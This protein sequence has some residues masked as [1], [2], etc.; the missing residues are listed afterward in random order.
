MPRSSIFHKVSTSDSLFLSTFI[1][2]KCDSFIVLSSFADDIKMHFDNK[3]V[4]DCNMLQQD[5]DSMQKWC[6]D[7]CMKLNI[8][9]STIIYL[10]TK[11]KVLN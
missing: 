1:N 4:D 9:N 11:L 7:N 2:N 8:D 3:N 5:V 6:L 10:V